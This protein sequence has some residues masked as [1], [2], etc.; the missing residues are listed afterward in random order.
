MVLDMEINMIQ[1]KE[2][3]SAS[4]DC[5]DLAFHASQVLL[6]S[7]NIDSASAKMPVRQLLTKCCATGA[8]KALFSQRYLW[9]EKLPERDY[10]QIYSESA[11]RRNYA[12]LAK[13]TI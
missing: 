4:G 9:S 1:S 7:M 3:G 12:E 2:N 6:E 13:S 10:Q 8:G 5:R 11:M